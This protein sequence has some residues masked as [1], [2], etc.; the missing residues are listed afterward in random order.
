MAFLEATERIGRWSKAVGEGV[1]FPETRIAIPQSLTRIGLAS[2]RNG[3]QYWVCQQ[4][5]I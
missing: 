4:N 2:M 1:F 5:S 3:D